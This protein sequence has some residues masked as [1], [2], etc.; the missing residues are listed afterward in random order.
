M[1]AS[2]RQGW[3]IPHCNAECTCDVRCN[4]LLSS[5]TVSQTLVFVLL[6]FAMKS[7]VRHVVVRVT[8]SLFLQW[9][10]L[11]CSQLQNQYSH[12]QL[13]ALSKVLTTLNWLV[14]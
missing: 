14:L 4:A 6:K 11:F 1:P 3:P 5:V 12:L 9:S 13:L 2:T 10:F 7:H 8:S